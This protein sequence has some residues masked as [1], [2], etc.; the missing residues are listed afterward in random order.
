MIKI[1]YVRSWHNQNTR[2]ILM[3]RMGVS[4]SVVINSL[5]QMLCEKLVAYARRKTTQPRDMYDVVWL[6]GQGAKLD[7][8][9]L[10]KNKIKNLAV[11]V[12]Q[13]L[14]KEGVTEEMKRKLAPFLFVPGDEKKIDMFRQV[15]AVV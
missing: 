13:R 7:R 15:I 8:D 1:D 10:T 11:Q 12:N 5:D 2:V 14:A 3:Q 9:F 4:Q 6:S